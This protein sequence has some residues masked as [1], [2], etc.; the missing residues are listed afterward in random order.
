MSGAFTKRLL[1]GSTDG[2]L[3]QVGQT[4]TPGDAVHTSVVGVTDFDEVWLYANNQSAGA[5]LLTLEIDGTTIAELIEVSIP[6]ESGLFLVLPG[7][8]LQNGATIAAFAGT[9]NVINL[10]GW[11]NRIAA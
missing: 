7:V 4:A 6:A 9:T 3:I 10:M 1:S 2:K 11:V 5:V 8:I